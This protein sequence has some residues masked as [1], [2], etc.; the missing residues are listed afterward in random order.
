MNK[1]LKFEASWCGQCKALDKI[2]LTVDKNIK[3]EHIDVDEDDNLDLVQKFDILN[4]PTL[5]LVNENMEELV[6]LHGVQTKEAIEKMYNTYK[7]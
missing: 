5:I 7:D 2:L 3:I 4:I 6:R 1:I